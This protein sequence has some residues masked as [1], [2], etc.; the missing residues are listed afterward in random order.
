MAAMAEAVAFTRQVAPENLDLIMQ[1]ESRM[2]FAQ[3][4]NKI[5]QGI[6]FME[7]GSKFLDIL[8]DGTFRKD[9]RD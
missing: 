6:I 7:K 5:N 9:R 1:T 8:L 3:A 2:R 4:A